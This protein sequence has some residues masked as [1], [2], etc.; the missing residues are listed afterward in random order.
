MRSFFEV[1]NHA[2]AAG[3]GQFFFTDRESYLAAGGHKEIRGSLHD[4]IQLPRTYRTAGLRTDIF[5]G[6]DLATVRMY[7]NAREVWGGLQKN[8]SEGLGHPRLIVPVSLLLFIGQILP[9]LAIGFSH[10]LSPVGFYIF[11]GS[12]FGLVVATVCWNH[13]VF[14]ELDWCFAPPI[15]SFAFA[16][17]SVDSVVKADAGKRRE[18][19]GT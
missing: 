8:A 14:S 3:C 6:G 15:G 2:F 11:F 13:Q 5:D 16:D 19:E 4:G 7:S 1:P 12:C 9:F 18:L 10:L 17:D